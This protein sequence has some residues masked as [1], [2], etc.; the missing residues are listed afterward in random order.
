[1]EPRLDPTGRSSMQE[2]LFVKRD[3]TR[4]LVGLR[5]LESGAVM[6]TG[7]GKDDTPASIRPYP[8]LSWDPLRPR[9]PT[10]HLSLPPRGTKDLELGSTSIGQ[11]PGPLLHRS[12]ETK[13][14]GTCVAFDSEKEPRQDTCRVPQSSRPPLGSRRVPRV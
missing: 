4:V 7:P 2:D 11:V 1:M 13:H 12:P 9:R 3:H 6:G 5:P 10:P 8:L 14:R